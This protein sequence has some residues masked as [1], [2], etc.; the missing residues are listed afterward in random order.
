VANPKGGYRITSDQGGTHFNFLIFWQIE[1][2][3]ISLGLC[4]KPET[5][6]YQLFWTL[7][8]Q[9]IYFF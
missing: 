2:G 4:Q 3:A 1:A 6:I 8:C 7:C 5:L 9:S